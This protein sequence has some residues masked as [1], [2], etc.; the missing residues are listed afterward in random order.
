MPPADAACLRTV[1]SV[2]PR[3]GGLE[4]RVREDGLGFGCVLGGG[5]RGLRRGGSG[6]GLGTELFGVRWF[7]RGFGGIRWGDV[8]A[9]EFAAEGFHVFGPVAFLAAATVF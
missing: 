2:L 5:G 4:E 7:G 1:I 3:R 8:G 9:V 6:G